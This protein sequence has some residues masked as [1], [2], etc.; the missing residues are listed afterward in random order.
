MIQCGRT[1]HVPR[2]TAVLGYTTLLIIMPFDRAHVWAAAM[3]FYVVS[4]SFASSPIKKK[5]ITKETNKERKP[6][7]Y[8]HESSSSIRVKYQH[9]WSLFFFFS[10]LMSPVAS[11]TSVRWSVASSKW[12]CCTAFCAMACSSLDWS[13]GALLAL[14]FLAAS[15]PKQPLRESGDRE[16]SE[17][18]GTKCSNTMRC[19]TTLMGT[20]VG[21]R[22]FRKRVWRVDV[23][24]KILY[25]NVCADL[26]MNIY[27]AVSY[28]VFW[29][30]QEH[31]V[32]YYLCADVCRNI[33]L[34]HMIAVR[35]SGVEL[36]WSVSSS[37]QQ[38]VSFPK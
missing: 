35:N 3:Y 12:P 18:F 2:P 22:A 14:A 8:M 33:L 19:T 37:V 11:R 34:C 36:F 5:E 13:R 10:H 21:E 17:E 27:T 20:V 26:Y 15:R 7:A 6:I 4:L 9:M 25:H 38:S 30:L 16:Q 28:D 24:R 23:F 32:S 29:C 1:C 31:T